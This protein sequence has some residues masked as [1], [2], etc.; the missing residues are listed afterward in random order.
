MISKDIEQNLPL[1]LAPYWEFL[2]QP[3][4][5]KLLRQK[6]AANRC[7]RSDDINIVVLVRERGVRDLIKRFNETEIDWSVVEK[8]LTS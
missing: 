1:E 2:L 3:K 8:Q 4:L 5:K 6:V 7:V